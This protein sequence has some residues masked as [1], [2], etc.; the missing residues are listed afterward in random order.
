MENLSFEEAFR[1]LEETVQALEQGGLDLEEMLRLY[2]RGIKLYKI[3][4]EHLEAAELRVKQLSLSLEGNVT[5]EP[6][7]PEP[8]E[9]GQ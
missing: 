1:Q 6:V 4:S 3:C 5:L 8:Q 7:P 9:S 2:E